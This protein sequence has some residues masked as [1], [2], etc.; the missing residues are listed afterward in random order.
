MTPAEAAEVLRKLN[1]WRRVGTKDRS[2]TAKH[3]RE[4][5]TDALIAE[6]E[7]THDR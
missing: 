2:L 3:V 1:E 6:L 4:A 5:L 7:K